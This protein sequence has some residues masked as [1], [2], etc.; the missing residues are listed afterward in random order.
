MYFILCICTML[1]SVCKLVFI[2]NYV[3]IKS[4]TYYFEHMIPLD[5]SQTSLT[6][7]LIFPNN[8]IHILIFHNK[9]SGKSRS[10]YIRFHLVPLFLLTLYVGTIKMMIGKIAIVI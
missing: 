2:H 1:I 9:A 10:L 3:I 5:T 7:P 8:H 6:Y 4:G